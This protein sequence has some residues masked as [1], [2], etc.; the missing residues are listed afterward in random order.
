MR[1]IIKLSRKNEGLTQEEY[2]NKF[3]ISRKTLSEIENNK[4][5]ISLDLAY[6]IANTYGLL[7]EEI[8]ENEFRAQS[9]VKFDFEEQR[10]K[11]YEKWLK[12]LITNWRRKKVDEIISMFSYDCEYYETPFEKLN[13]KDQINKVWQEIHDQKIK[14]ITSHIIC[15]QNNNCVARVILEDTSNTII[16]MIY[17]FELNDNGICTKFIQ[18]YSI[19]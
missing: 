4:C 8:F 19:K 10:R 5:N 2:A 11:R 18:W 17:N 7:V 3:G 15:I 1:N 12:D 14:K 16:D 6:K 13:S 9:K